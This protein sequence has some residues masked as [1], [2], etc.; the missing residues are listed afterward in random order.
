MSKELEYPSEYREYNDE[1]LSFWSSENLELE[2]VEDKKDIKTLIKS[3]D[4]AYDEI[5]GLN[6]KI[7]EL[8]AN[9]NNIKKE[10]LDKKIL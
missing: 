6:Q 1:S 7:A 9:I 5:F 2:Y 8:Y 4:K 3:L 10:L